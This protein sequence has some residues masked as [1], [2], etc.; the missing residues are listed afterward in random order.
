MKTGLLVGRIVQLLLQAVEA[1]RVKAGQESR[2][3]VG[4]LTQS[5]AD[6]V[7]RVNGRSWRNTP[8]HLKTVGSARLVMF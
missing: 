2:V 6:I 4:L 7:V 3:T 1:E 5:T 8:G